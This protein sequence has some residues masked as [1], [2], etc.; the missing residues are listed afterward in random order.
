VHPAVPDAFQ[1]GI[2]QKTV[3]SPRGPKP[4]GNGLDPFE[5][6]VVSLLRR[7]ATDRA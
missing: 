4:G 2:L 5:A 6:E 3:V 1:S 7:R